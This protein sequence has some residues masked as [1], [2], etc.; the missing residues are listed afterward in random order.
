[1]H[2][3]PLEHD[4]AF[5]LGVVFQSRLRGFGGDGCGGL[6]EVRHGRLGSFRYAVQIGSPNPFS[7]RAARASAA[8]SSSDPSKMRSRVA[9]C[10]AASCITPM[11]LFPLIS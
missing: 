5:R 10:S 8:F 2:T 9:P 11:M 1:S 6:E 7:N 3:D 4:L